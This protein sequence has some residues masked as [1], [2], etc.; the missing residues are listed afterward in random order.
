MRAKSV[1][2]VLLLTGLSLFLSPAA[3]ADA[4]TCGGGGDWAGAFAHCVKSGAQTNDYISHHSGHVFT[5]RPACAVGGTALCDE[6]GTCQVDGHDGRLFDVYED[7]VILGWQACLTD[8]E[9]EH[10]GGITPGA[11]KRAFQRLDW[12]ASPMVIQPPNGRTLVNFDTNFYTPNTSPTTQTV[13]LLGATIT[14]EA[15]PVEYVWHFG[16]VGATASDLTTADPGAAYPNL[17]V[18]F[19]YLHTGVV[20]P[21]LDTTYS[22]RYRIG[23][24]AWQ[25][26]PDTLT[27]TGPPQDLQVVSATPHLVGY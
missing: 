19:R 14:I 10:L 5:I 16:G 25:Q 24:G 18:T 13:T 17:R 1:T 7:G 20:R 11:V 12:P 9:A 4:N 15:S 22:G 3:Y 8:Q 23:N 26:I 6:P 21:S 2:L 27:V